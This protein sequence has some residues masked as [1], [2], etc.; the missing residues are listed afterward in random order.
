MTLWGRENRRRNRSLRHPQENRL[1]WICVSVTG[2]TVVGT[3][4]RAIS[5]HSTQPLLVL[6]VPALVFFVRGQL[7]ARQRV[8]GVRITEHQFPEAYRMVVD[9]ARAFG[10]PRPPDAYLVPGH[11][12]VNAFA[13]GHGLR[14][15]VAITSDL[16]EIGVRNGDPDALR[17]VIGHEVGHIAAGHAS[18]WR[19]FGVSIAHLI[20][21]LGSS[22]S[23]AQEYTAD[24][25][26][27]THLP[28]SS[29][30]VRVL[31]SGTHAYTRV[32]MG[33]MADRARTDRG[34]SLLLYHLFTRRPSN[35]RRMAALRDR[36]R[37]GRVFL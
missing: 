24:N 8:N 2:L 30:A 12:Q 21:G 10:M 19:Q 4:D 29:H 7:Y 22:L 34:C 26:A 28:G 14:R 31:A 32:N 20:P 18:F 17:F 37:H 27:H 35:I 9:A 15:Y 3:L 16:F 5:E 36:S 23:R 11:G 6:L 13:S 25:H 1:L 33:E